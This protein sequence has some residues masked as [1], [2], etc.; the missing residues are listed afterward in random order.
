MSKHDKI[1]FVSS[2]YA[3]IHEFA[4]MIK[5]FNTIIAYFAMRRK[6]RSHYKTS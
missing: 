2:P 4:M 3:V 5:S 1:V 6:R